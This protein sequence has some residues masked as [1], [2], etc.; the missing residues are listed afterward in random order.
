MLS[1]CLNK[2]ISHIILVIE[3]LGSLS[4]H[5][6][7]IKVYAEVEIKLHT[8]FFA[9]FILRI[10]NDFTNPDRTNKCTVLL[11]C[12]SLLIKLLHFNVVCTVLR[13][14]MHIYQYTN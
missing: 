11:L 12:I 14:A 2:F 6:R 13:A 7:K 9:M 3:A 5:L 8:L 4:L 1:K 10:V